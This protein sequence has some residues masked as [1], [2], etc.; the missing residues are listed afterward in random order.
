MHVD[1]GDALV[2]IDGENAERYQ[3]GYPSFKAMRA[4][5]GNQQV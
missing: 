4:G 1:V 2:C 3:G 5:D